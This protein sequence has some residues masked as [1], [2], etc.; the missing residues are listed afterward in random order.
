MSLDATWWATGFAAVRFDQ[1][2]AAATGVDGSIAG[3]WSV[4][5][6]KNVTSLAGMTTYGGGSQSKNY[7]YWFAVK[8]SDATKI[9]PL[10]YAKITADETVIDPDLDGLLTKKVAGGAIMQYNPPFGQFGAPASSATVVAMVWHEDGAA[11]DYSLH[12]YQAHYWR[13]N[14]AEVIG[15]ILRHVGLASAFIATSLWSDC[16]TAQAAMATEPVVAY[17]RDI[18]ESIAEALKRVARHCNDIMC[19]NMAGQISLVS[20]S[21]PPAGPT[22]LS[23]SLT[24]GPIAWRYEAK[25]LANKADVSHGQ[26]NYEQ[27]PATGEYPTGTWLATAVWEPNAASDSGGLLTTSYADA[28]S[29][30]KHGVIVLDNTQ[31]RILEG[32][33]Y[34]QRPAYHLPYIYDEDYKDAVMARLAAVDSALRRELVVRQDFRGLDYD[35][36][37]EVTNIAVTSDGDTIAAATCIR[38]KLDFRNLQI[39]SW[40]LEEV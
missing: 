9:M 40:L 27:S 19:V 39:T 29:Q 2:W 18:G 24:V 26:W 16:E 28:T 22:S 4:Y 25:Y 1:D 6:F 31:H 38:K 5:V 23:T 32:G 15:A 17:R 11:T 30:T 12:H 3:G 34:V 33:A 14:P 13:G 10:D 37:Y 35:I 8:D 7:G 21:S 36:G 20:R